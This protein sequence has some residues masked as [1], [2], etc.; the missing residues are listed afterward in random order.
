MQLLAVFDVAGKIQYF[1]ST[2]FP[3]ISSSGVISSILFAA[4]DPTQCFEFTISLE[5][6][7]HHSLH[8]HLAIH[9]D[10]LLTANTFAVFATVTLWR[11]HEVSRL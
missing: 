7:F 2:S 3:L 4:S 10:S 6:N 9:G 5:L 8:I 11:R 1:A